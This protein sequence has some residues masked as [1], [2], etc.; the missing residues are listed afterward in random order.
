MANCITISGNL[1][2]DPEHKTLPSGKQICNFTIAD[3]FGVKTAGGNWDNKAQFWLCT[4]WEKM[5]KR[6]E[7][8]VKGE[9]ICVVGKITEDEW[10]S[11][12]QLVKVKKVTVSDVMTWKRA[13]QEDRVASQLE[14]DGMEVGG[15]RDDLPV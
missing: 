1:T 9:Q 11:K 10:E 2:K 12:G 5:C 15:Y 13:N 14:R 4:V 6:L 8:F 7:G 3:N